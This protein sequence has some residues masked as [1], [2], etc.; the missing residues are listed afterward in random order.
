MTDR[1][2]QLTPPDADAAEERALAVVR[3]AYAERAPASRRTAAR[4]TRR[5]LAVAVATAVVVGAV[6]PAGRAVIDH[7]R[8]FVGTERPTLP[9]LELP[10][11]RLLVRS[12][13]GVWVVQE[14]AAARLLGDYDDAA[15]SPLGRF[16][17]ATRANELIAVTP[18]GKI[19]W[20][21]THPSRTSLPSWSGSA[22]D[23]RIAYLRGTRL[24]WVT[25]DGQTDSQLA[26][27]AVAPVRPAWKP[28]STFELAYALPGGEIVVVTKLGWPAVRRLPGL[29]K[30]QWAADGRRLLAVSQRTTAVFD[31]RGRRV[32][33]APASASER[34]VD[35]TFVGGTRRVVVASH[36]AENDLSRVRELATGRVLFSARGKIAQ[37]V[38]SPDGSTLLLTWPDTDQ[39]ILVPLEPHRGVTTVDQVS[40]RFRSTSFPS[41]S[42][43]QIP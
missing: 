20:T 1:L 33:T 5:V 31:D 28:G 16:V 6:S 18:D 19:R 24:R 10:G 23:T 25:G 15:W 4:T 36:S 38:A 9:A 27:G 37:V 30:L 43:W 17:V 42:G 11:G 2:R 41:V 22:T 34:V 32:A 26:Q 35:A 7:V 39:W 8:E 29:L 40:E 12:D 14:D 13:V 21:R 3:E